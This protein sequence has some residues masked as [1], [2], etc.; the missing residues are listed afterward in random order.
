MNGF[1][2]GTQA[3]QGRK[4]NHD[5]EPYI[6]DTGW[7]VIRSAYDATLP[8]KSST[9]DP[10]SEFDVLDNPI[11]AT[12]RKSIGIWENFDGTEMTGPEIAREW[13]KNT[14]IEREWWVPTAVS[15]AA[16]DHARRVL[17]RL[18]AL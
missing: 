9:Y 10:R 6:I 8:V 13:L 2:S 16:L 1:T 17:N 5:R 15:D 14:P 18:A 7:L 3:L 11:L 4:V 12:V